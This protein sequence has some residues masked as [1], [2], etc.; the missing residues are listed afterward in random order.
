MCSWRS[1]KIRSFP[2]QCTQLLTLLL[3]ISCAHSSA[4]RHAQQGE[5]LQLKADLMRKTPSPGQA[6]ELSRAVLIHEVKTAQDQQDRQFIQTLRGCSAGL[7]SA[8]VSRAKT[9]DGVGA[10]AAMLLLELDQLE[11]P[12]RFATDD[13]GAWRA[14]AARA[15]AEHREARQ[16]Y[17][18]DPDERVRRAA[19]IAA[20]EANDPADA[21]HLLEIARLDP[22][23]AIRSH[24]ILILGTYKSERISSALRDRFTNM[25]EA[26]RLSVVQAWGTPQLYSHGGQRELERLIAHRTGL[27]VV[28]AASLLAR[29]PVSEVSNP[30]ITRLVR[31]MN[32]GTTDEQRLALVMMPVSSTETTTAL[33]DKTRAEDQQVAVIAWSRLLAHP[34]FQKRAEDQLSTLATSSPESSLALQAEA[35]LAAGGSIKVKPLLK[36]GLNDKDPSIRKVSGIGLV[37]LGLLAE[38]ASLIGDEDADVR[39]TIACRISAAPSLKVNPLN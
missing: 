12:D 20:R 33:L 16:R 19:L 36:V 28:A 21:D 31:F 3:A 7:P 15:S 32:E 37:R 26:L 9:H 8:L 29:D 18:L 4:L 25:D 35:A 13:D 39:R 10:E 22:D 14:L 24:A 30:A 38:A 23:P 17:Y 5:L 11:S 6:R 34:T 27:E 1:F 2:T